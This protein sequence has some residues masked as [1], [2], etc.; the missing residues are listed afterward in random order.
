MKLAEEK[1]IVPLLNSADYNAGVSMDSIN[2]KN[3][4]R[5]CVIMTFGAIT[6]NAG[7]KVYSGTTAA[8]ATSAMPFRYALGSAAIAS[9]SADVLA[10]AT[11]AVASSG[12]TLTAA[13]YASKMLVLD[14]DAA[15]M[16]TANNEEWLTVVI[17]ASASAGICHAVA[18][19]D[20]RYPS[21][22]SGTVLA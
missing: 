4:H 18:V 8:A 7:L 15:D 12:I 17:D 20:L 3:A 11:T 5:A 22:V 1:K 19:L 13:T 9:S 21:S 2:M 16:D 14:I 6:G 10:A